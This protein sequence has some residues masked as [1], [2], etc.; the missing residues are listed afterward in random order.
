VIAAGAAPELVLLGNLL[1]DDL[2]FPDGRTR[3][4]Q[5][6]GAILYASLA[7]ALWGA[8]TGCVSLR[9][10]DYPADALERLRRRGVA[11]EGVAP[12]GRPGVRTWLLYEGRV[13]RV[14]HRLGGPTHEEVSPEPAQVP[15]AWRAARAFHL[16]PMPIAVQERLVAALN[17]RALDGPGTGAIT[18]PAEQRDA[19]TA[20]A[21]GT[22]LTIDPHELVTEDSLPRWRA[23]LA[24]VDVFFPSEDELRLADAATDPHAALRRLAGGRLRFVAYKR[25]LRGGILYDARE[26]RFHEWAARTNGIVDPTGA[27]DAFAAGFLTAQLEGRGIE[28]CLQR[29]VVTASFALEAWGSASLLEATRADAEARQRAWFAAEATA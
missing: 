1:V 3:M 19:V 9:G 22:L 16:A 7:A 4:G 6:G 11:L 26:D 5:P 14:V 27:G 20:R 13:R 2:V 12:L 17:E 8:R 18:R 21:G 29:G 15:A 24:Q 10:E 23:L 28:E 25:G